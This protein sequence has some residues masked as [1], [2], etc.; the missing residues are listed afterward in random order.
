MRAV[1]IGS[2]PT[3]SD[4]QPGTDLLVNGG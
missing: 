3:R 1:K 2:R 4:R